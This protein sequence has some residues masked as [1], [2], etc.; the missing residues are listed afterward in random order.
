[1]TI[2]EERAA[3]LRLAREMAGFSSPTEAA[4]R[5]RWH[6]STYYGHE[7]GS[8]GI[9][10]SSTT[11]AYAKAF[12]I[13]ESWLLTGE[14]AGPISDGVI[15]DMVATYWRLPV[16]RRAQFLALVLAPLAGAAPPEGEE[17]RNDHSPPEGGATPRRK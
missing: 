17:D 2:R 7:N 1:M 3:R 9:S 5:F 11:A 6:L 14:G 16:D 12:G 4:T 8:R 10:R 13:T 15:E